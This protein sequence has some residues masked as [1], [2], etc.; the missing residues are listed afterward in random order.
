MA[1]GPRGDGRP[2]ALPCTDAPPYRRRNRRHLSRKVEE[3]MPSEAGDRNTVVD[4]SWS[5]ER[6]ITQ[7]T[8]GQVHQLAVEVRD[9]R[10]T[11]RGWTRSY[12]LKQLAIQASLE[13]LAPAGSPRLEVDIEVG[14]GGP[15]NLAG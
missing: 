5:V 8:G 9:D 6:Q 7:R 12:Y 11:V 14:A 13:A 1:A 15:P 10:V 3:D 4:L 2:N